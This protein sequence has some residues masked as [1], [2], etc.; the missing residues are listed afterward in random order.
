MPWINPCKAT[1]LAPP[2]KLE[3]FVRKVAAQ[4]PEPGAMAALIVEAKML[5]G[6]LP[7]FAEVKAAGMARRE[8]EGNIPF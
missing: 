8:D 4:H 7:T 5:L 2:S 6:E 1:V 3:R